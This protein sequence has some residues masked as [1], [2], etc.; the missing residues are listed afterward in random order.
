MWGIYGGGSGLRTDLDAWADALGVRDDDA[1][2]SAL[3][4]VSTDL[5]EVTMRLDLVHASIGGGSSVYS[6]VIAENVRASKTS[7]SQ[8]LTEIALVEMA[9]KRHARGVS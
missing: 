8:A 1:A 2:L 5:N 4:R 3:R 9:F 7:A 6:L